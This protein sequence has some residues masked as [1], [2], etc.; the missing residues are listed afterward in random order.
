M[1]DGWVLLCCESCSVFH[2]LLSLFGKAGNGMY[3]VFMLLGCVCLI[4]LSVNVDVC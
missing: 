2:C 3:E 4:L 1:V